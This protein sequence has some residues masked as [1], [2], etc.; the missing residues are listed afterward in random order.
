ML[1]RIVVGLVGFGAR[2][3]ILEGAFGC[4]C[5]SDDFCRQFGPIF[6]FPNKSRGHFLTHWPATVNYCQ[7]PFLESRRHICLTTAPQTL[8]IA[9]LELIKTIV[10]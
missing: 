3:I 2:R 9:S 7:T 5:S 1:S 6:S 8:Y 4:R 10:L